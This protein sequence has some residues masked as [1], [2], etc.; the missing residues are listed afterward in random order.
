MRTTQSIQSAR[1]AMGRVSATALGVVVLCSSACADH[2]TLTSPS[3][4]VQ[5]RPSLPGPV[6]VGPSNAVLAM[7]DVTITVG[8]P[9]DE[10]GTF[11]FITKFALTETGGTS[12]ATI[13]D[14]WVSVAGGD[15]S[16]TGAGCWR[17]P[18]RVA[19]GATTDAFDA[20]WDG[21]AYCAPFGFGRVPSIVTINVSFVDDDGRAGSVGTT[22]T[23]TR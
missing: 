22:T 4:F 20:G 5:P 11:Y 15:S 7:S 14:I 3:L 2:P 21:L 23:A 18:I 1:S 9:A 19:P 16:G 13:K 10:P 8:G 17:T 6:A 12:G